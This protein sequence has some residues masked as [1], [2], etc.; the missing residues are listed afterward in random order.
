MDKLEEILN[1]VHAVI[2]GFAEGF[3]PCGPRHKA[4]EEGKRLIERE[5]WYYQGGRVAGKVA[6]PL[7]IIGILLLAKEVLL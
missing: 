7:F 2:I 6:F 5:Y 1:E 4:P 3:C